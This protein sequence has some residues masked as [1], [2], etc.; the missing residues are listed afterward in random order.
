MSIVC[1]SHMHDS[2]TDLWKARAMIG[3][4]SYVLTGIRLEK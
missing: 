2:I 3:K 1:G 4:W